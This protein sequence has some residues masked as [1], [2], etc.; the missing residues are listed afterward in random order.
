M[1]VSDLYGYSCV[2]SE[3][4]EW[5]PVLS[6]DNGKAAGT[7]KQLSEHRVSDVPR[8]YPVSRPAKLAI[9][10][11]WISDECVGTTLILEPNIGCGRYLLG[12]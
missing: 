2:N 10:M 12:E 5:T 1:A 9:P 11:V 7:L 8:S 3:E 4:R 6:R